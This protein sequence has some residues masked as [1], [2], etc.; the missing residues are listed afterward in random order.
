MEFDSHI[1]DVVQKQAKTNDE[2]GELSPEVLDYIYK[3]RLF[4]LFLPPEL[5][6]NDDAPAGGV[7]Y[8]RGV[9]VH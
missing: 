9:S 4:K 2:T 1:A 8:F 7:A 6:G 5:G 3:H